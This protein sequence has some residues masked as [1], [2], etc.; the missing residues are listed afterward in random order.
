MPFRWTDFPVQIVHCVTGSGDFKAEVSFLLHRPSSIPEL[1]HHQQWLTPF[2][3]FVIFKREETAD[4]KGQF[5]L[6]DRPA[7]WYKLYIILQDVMT[8]RQMFPF[9]PSRIYV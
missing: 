4:G 1:F 3:I 2:Y 9:L 7:D 8:S 5:C 6:F